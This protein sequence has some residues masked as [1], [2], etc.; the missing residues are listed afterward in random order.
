MKAR[1]QMLKEVLKVWSLKDIKCKSMPRQKCDEGDGGEQFCS[2]QAHQA[3]AHLLNT[4]FH[5]NADHLT[6]D[7]KEL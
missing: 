5:I 4:V 6:P 2:E 3:K 1:D 7:I